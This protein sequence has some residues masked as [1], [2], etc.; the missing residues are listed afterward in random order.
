MFAHRRPTGRPGSPAWRRAVALGAGA[1]L[2]WTGG[3]VAL[4]PLAHAGTIT[5]TVHCVLPAG[6][7]EA[8]GPQ[9][10]GI[11]LTPDVVDPG[12]KVHAK[13]TLGPSPATS[14]IGLSDVPTTPSVDLAMSGGATGTVTVTGPEVSLDVPSGKPI[15]IPP[16]EGDFL[17]PANASGP[18]TF[19]PLRNIT[20]T[21]VLGSNYT[22]TCE[23]TAGGGSIGTVTAEG[24]AGQPATLIAPTAAVRPST[25]V[26]LSG[27][28]WTAGATPVPSLCA[29]DGGGCD[30]GKFASSSLAINASGQLTGSAVLA[31][32]G[33]VPDGSYLVK[34]GDGTKEATAPL[35]VRAF[36]P[37]GPR[38]IALSR[39]SGPVGS[40]ITVTGSDYYQDRWINTVGLDA[41]GATLDDTAVYVKSRPDGTFSVDFTVSDP[42]IAAIQ[43]D[44][45]ND[46]ATVLTT[47]FTVT[48]ATATLSAGTA[49]V[50]PGGSIAVSGDG[51][52]SG[53]TP[54]AALC[55][56]DGT[57]CNAAGISGSTLRIAADG[58]LAGTVTAAGSTAR[59][60]YALQVTAGGQQALTE[61]TVAPT[62][63]VLTPASGPKGTAVTVLGQGFAKVATVSITG[64]RAD[65]SKTSDAVRTKVVGLD[66]AFS[67]TFTVNAAD[68]VAL[69]VREV[70]VNPR[71]E[72][73]AFT[74]QDGTVPAG[75]SFALSP[76]EGPP[77]TVVQVTGRGFAPVATV[78]VTGRTA[79]GKQTADS[80]VT[81]V[82]GLDG[83]FALNFTVR[84]PATK[85]IRACEV[86]VNGKTV[87]QLFTVS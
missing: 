7:G 17:I 29:A 49:K 78:S 72:T 22:T 77:G 21:K 45:G 16:Y 62:F 28:R 11:E 1:V 86:L 57:G 46:P 13:V 34:V 59:G 85:A 14:G 64:L 36:V 33:A 54:A 32:A 48:E 68:T 31:A 35:T 20:R 71:T 39:G 26:A 56:A 30:A 9:Q 84:D 50:K 5:P 70:L 87:Q 44:E 24:S 19:T 65:G 8:T 74:V 79:D 55:A 63:I 53:V 43:V 80:Y 52:P 10:F 75:A 42:A 27:S 40:V 12:G 15:E 66:G 47:P 37:D 3:T 81:R 2:A 58:T 4:A 82:I 23:I 76:P 83:T 18:I 38:A 6:Q 60:V 51:W 69:R 67:Q 41:G 73:A 25:A 61:L